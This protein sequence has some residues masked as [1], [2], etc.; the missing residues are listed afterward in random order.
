MF[1]A[2]PDVYLDEG[3]FTFGFGTGVVGFGP[4]SKGF[5]DMLLRVENVK[6]NGGA[7]LPELGL[8]SQ[9]QRVPHIHNSSLT[10]ERSGSNWAVM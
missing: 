5:K 8:R 9:V 2:A 7:A 10:I 4:N 1:A 3:G 6:S